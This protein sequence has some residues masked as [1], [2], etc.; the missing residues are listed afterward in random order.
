MADL[1]REGFAIGQPV[2]RVGHLIGD[3]IVDIAD[4]A[5]G[6]VVV[7]RVHPAGPIKAAALQREGE[8]HLA[9]NFEAGKE[10]GQFDPPL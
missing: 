4:E 7:V 1:E 9:R 3:R 6:D 8:P 10:S 5:Q 2:E